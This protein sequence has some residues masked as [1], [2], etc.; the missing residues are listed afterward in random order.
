MVRHIVTWNHA[1]HIPEAERGENAKRLKSE[2]E[3]LKDLVP[4]VV[5]ITVRTEM[6]P[7]SNRALMLDS[8]FESTEALQ[9]YITHPEH[10]RAGQFVRAVTQD[11][12][13]VDYA[14]E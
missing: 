12:A 8:L 10:V 11:R 1:E 6:L 5:S 7:S 2:L 14:E 9:G 3:A 4:G 13:C